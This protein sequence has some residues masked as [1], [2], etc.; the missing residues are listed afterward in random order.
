MDA[1]SSAYIVGPTPFLKRGAQILERK[2]ILPC[3]IHLSLELMTMCG[4]GMCG[5]CLCGDRLTCQW[6]TFV[7]YEYITKEAPDLL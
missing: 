1:M 6:G 2:G 3:R 5:E 4:V 7:T